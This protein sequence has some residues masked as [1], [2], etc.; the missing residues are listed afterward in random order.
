[1]S[2]VATPVGSRVRVLIASDHPATRSGVRLALA[3]EAECLEAD[4]PDGAV[5]A[6]AHGRADIYLIDFDPPRR[7]IRTAAEITSTMPEA[8]VVVMTS[9]VD[10]NEVMEAVRAGA[11]GYLAQ[12]IDPDRL[13]HVIRGVLRGEAAIPRRLVRLM[14]EELRVGRGPRHLRLGESGRVE[15]TARESEVVEGLRQGLSTREMARQLG[16]SDVTVRRHVSAVHQKL[17]T[18][19]RAELT[20]LLANGNSH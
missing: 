18:G 5:V 2:A 10:D 3:E 8:L 19:S 6:A 20:R 13:P 16:I 7:A 14:A 17:G 4:D 11:S 9:R 1:V 15:L 12:T